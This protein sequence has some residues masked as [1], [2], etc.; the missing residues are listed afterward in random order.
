MSDLK[1]HLL[2]LFLL[3][4]CLFLIVYYLVRPQWRRPWRCSYLMR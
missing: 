1:A 3:K 2:R 4:H